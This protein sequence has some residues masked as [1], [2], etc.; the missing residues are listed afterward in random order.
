[1]IL[2]FVEDIHNAVLEQCTQENPYI[3][4]A[5]TSMYLALGPPWQQNVTL[6]T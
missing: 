2:R 6:V 1:M 4:E 3:L 5:T